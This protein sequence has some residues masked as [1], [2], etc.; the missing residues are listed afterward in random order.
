MT[1]WEYK[2][3]V[4]ERAGNEEDFS[5]NWSY[6]PW[7]T[8][9]GEVKQALLASLGDLGKDGW[10]LAGVMPTDLWSEGGRGSSSGVRSIACL[11]LFKRPL[12]GS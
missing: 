10:E 12:P 1:K 7:E 9:T 5:F 3:V 6:G 2:T 11:L 4:V 8:K